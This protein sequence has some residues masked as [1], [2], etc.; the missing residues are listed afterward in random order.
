MTG[1]PYDD[2]TVV[3]DDAP[4]SHDSSGGPL[5]EP[6]AKRRKTPPSSPQNHSGSSSAC[7]RYVDPN[8][9]TM[10]DH[11][12]TSM[13]PH[14]LPPHASPEPEELA[15]AVVIDDA[16]PVRCAND[17]DAYTHAI[18]P[19][20]VPDHGANALDDHQLLIW[21]EMH[22]PGAKK[23]AKMVAPH[24]RYVDHD[25][26]VGRLGHT[27]LNLISQLNKVHGNFRPNRDAAVLVEGFKSNKWV[28]ELAREHHKFNASSYY[29]LGEKDARSFHEYLQANNLEKVRQELK[30]KSIVLFDDGSYS[31]KQLYDHIR[32]IIDAI[33]AY[34]LEVASI[35][36]AVPFMTT[37]AERLIRHLKANKPEQLKCP[38]LIGDPFNIPTLADLDRSHAGSNFGPTVS[39]MWGLDE[40]QLGQLGLNVFQHK[41]PNS[42]SF[43]E[44]LA[45]GK[46][47]DAQGH[48]HQSKG[49]Y[50]TF[51]FISEKPCPYKQN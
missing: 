8:H 47:C 40:D 27:L 49:R 3:I 15:P 33:I 50:L 9:P 45:K 39:A 11:I 42:M 44:V 20:Q 32:G 19:P 12:F 10:F 38:I 23:A 7:S 43:P 25:E 35:A 6:A 28:A 2:D 41:L 4:S 37:H 51:P 30:G 26:F 31:G 48:H 29:R 1:M 22:P 18:R 36:I 21:A 16:I 24:I 13:P 14:P 17:K 46:V 34:K 5:S